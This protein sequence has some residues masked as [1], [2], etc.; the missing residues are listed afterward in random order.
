MS[1]IPNDPHRITVNSHNKANFRISKMGYEFDSSLD[2]WELD[3][4]R[5]LNLGRIRDID[6]S[7]QDGFRKALCRYAEELSAETCN[8]MFSNFNMYFDFTGYRSI[9]VAGLTKWRASLTDETEHRLGALKAFLIAWNEWRYPGIDDDVVQYLNELTLK[10][11]IKGKAV[12]SADVYSGPLTLNEQGAILDW[13]SNAF[14]INSINLTEYA[15]FLTLIFTGRRSVQIRSLRAVDIVYREDSKGHDYVIRFPR[16]KQTGVGF[17]KAFR[18][19]AINEDLYLVLENQ[20]ERSK[21]QVERI[22][23]K[24]LP[25]EIRQQIPIFL[26]E[27]RVNSLRDIDNLIFCLNKIPDFLHMTRSQSMILLRNMSVSCTA[28][29]ERTGEFINFTSRRFRYTKGTNLARRGV[30]GVALAEAL[31][32]SDTQNIDVYTGNTEE[33]AQQIDAIMSPILAPLAQAFAGKLIASERDALRAN[34]PHSR[35]KNDSANA[36][37]SCGTFTF[38]ASG[39]RA[40]YTCTY[41]QAWLDAPHEEVLNEILSERARQAD[42]GV[43]K[44]VIGSTDRL[45]LAVQQVVLMCE[46]EKLKNR[47]EVSIG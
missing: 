9:S 44:E 15:Y 33:M 21:L 35:V 25:L 46:R 30:T 19:I 34:D 18:S 27:D 1:L 45:L 14:N 47:R 6:G 5:V 22:L 23:G 39:Y 16:V 36:I 10:G 32:H 8:L 26:E 40:C 41:F 11:M 3:G 13:A 7:T 4:S 20:A 17:R 37:G 42:A 31:D 43:S 12:R 38:C 24:K 29:S 2:I 28:R